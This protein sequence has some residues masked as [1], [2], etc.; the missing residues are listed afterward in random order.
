MKTVIYGIML[1][2]L[3][4]CS[5]QHIHSNESAGVIPCRAI[6]I[7]ISDYRRV[8]GQ[9]IN[10]WIAECNGYKYVCT[11]NETDHKANCSRVMAG[12]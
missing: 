5:A 2:L 6:D 11:S 1:M 10:E 8:W 3:A 12:K 4:G 9:G 7:K